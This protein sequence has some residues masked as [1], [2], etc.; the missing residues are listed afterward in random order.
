MA[1]ESIPHLKLTNCMIE[2]GPLLCYLRLAREHPVTFSEPADPVEEQNLFVLL[3][4]LE[5]FEVAIP[6]RD[7]VIPKAREARLLRY[8]S[9]V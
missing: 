5:L 8:A 1:L 7:A 3:S 4:V 6:R 9:C 2:D